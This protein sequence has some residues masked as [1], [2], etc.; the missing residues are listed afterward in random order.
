ML[1]R[2]LERLL[3][4]RLGRPQMLSRCGEPIAGQHPGLL[5]EVDDSAVPPHS[6]R[7]TSETVKDV[8]EQ[9]L[10]IADIGGIYAVSR[11]AEGQDR[12]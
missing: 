8:E 5:V 3:A 12:R 11:R 6:G 2:C 7:G 4:V 9:N 1:D 10:R